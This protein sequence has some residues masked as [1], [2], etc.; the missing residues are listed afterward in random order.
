LAHPLNL[1]PLSLARGVSLPPRIKDTLMTDRP[2]SD[3]ETALRYRAFFE[4]GPDGVVVLDPESFRVVEFNDQA[5]RQLGYSREEF[6]RLAIPDID[7]SETPEQT[8]MTVATVLRDGRIDFETRHRTKFGEI[9]NVHVTA[10]LIEAGGRR[11]YHCIWRDI[12]DRKR[13]E[14]ALEKRLVTLT[15]PEGEGPAV[16]FE[17]LFNL[18]DIQRLQDEFAKATGV[19]SIITRPDGTPITA[20]SR[21]CRLCQDIIR[22]TPLGLTNCYRSDAELG[23]AKADGPMVQPCMSGGLWDAGAGISVGGHPVANW[24][25]GQVR[26]GTQTEQT[27]RTYARAIGADEDEVI[28]AF[29]EVPAMTHEQFVHVAQVLF[30]LANQL[31][32]MAY[33]N[34]QQARFISELRRAEREQRALQDQLGQARKIESIGRLAGGVAH[35]FNNMLSVILGHV[36]MALEELEPGHP[37]HGSLTEIDHAARRSADLV[38]QLLAFARKQTVSPRVLDLNATLDGLLSMLRRLIGENVRLSWR[39]GPDLPSVKIDPSQLDQLLTNLCVNARDSIEGAG[40]VR[41]STWHVAVGPEEAARREGVKPGTFVVL[42]VADNGC[43]MTPDVLEH[44]FEPF[45]TT[46]GVGR[47]TGLGLATV[48]GIVKQNEGFVEVKS[49]PRAGTTFS[50]FLPA[51][52]EARP[53]PPDAAEP[54]RESGAKKTILLV[55]DEEAIL[56]LGRRMLE[57][58]GYTVLTASKPA[59]AIAVAGS[60]PGDIDLLI[61]DVV[62]PEMNGRELARRLLSRHPGM[63]RLY[64][65]GYTADVIAHHGVLE[66]GIHFLQKPFTAQLLSARVAA[67]L[68]S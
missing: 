68:D 65:S 52:A 12:T 34:V 58:F 27:M 49:E 5:C 11:I 36:E 63:R 10:Q 60:H 45:F 23:R 16:S 30:T 28:D 39:A 8:A 54:A 48:Y 6:E 59:D 64:M 40:D 20:P 22:Q 3:H 61:T 53:A 50:I 67:A 2:S 43:G 7:A 18:D 51:F 14:E 15:R 4:Q 32:S 33:Q 44:V 56:T 37:L 57:R 29:R 55:E 25:I 66:E 31:S 1:A 46:K 17:D 13:F 9:R 47:G 41:I 42:E 38:R 19:A 62:M 35:D 26:D 21:F 24:L